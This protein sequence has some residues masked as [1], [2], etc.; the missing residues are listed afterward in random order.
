MAPVSSA[1]W[2]KSRRSG[3]TNGNC[4]E[5]TLNAVRDSKNS[6]EFLNVDLTGL[7]AAAKAGKLDR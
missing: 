4:V 6:G 3:G 1:V 2:R 7:L 5:V